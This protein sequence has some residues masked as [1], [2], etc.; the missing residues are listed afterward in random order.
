MKDDIGTWA[1]NTLKLVLLGLMAA[2]VAVMVMVV[3]S[4]V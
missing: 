3:W 2:A 4:L 1:K